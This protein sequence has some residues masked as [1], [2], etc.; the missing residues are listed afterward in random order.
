MFGDYADRP[1]DPA[2]FQPVCR[3]ASM[4]CDVA[5]RP[6]PRNRPVSLPRLIVVRLLKYSVQPAK[7][8]LNRSLA[9]E[10]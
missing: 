4:T 6:S 8:R 9:E 3:A 7:L 10:R 5:V 1:S 2:G